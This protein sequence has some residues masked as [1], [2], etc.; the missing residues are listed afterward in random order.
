M[1]RSLASPSFMTG[2]QDDL[3]APDIYTISNAETIN[4]VA[5]FAVMDEVKVQQVSVLQGGKAMLEKAREGLK[6][7]QSVQG[8]NAKGTGAFD[9]LMNS[10][11]SLSNVMR[12]LPTGA[13]G[14][15]KELGVLVNAAS[16][17]VQKGQG[18]VAQINGVKQTFNQLK[19]GNVFAK[20]DSIGS[21]INTLSGDSGVFSISNIKEQASTIAGVVNLASANGIK[22]AFGAILKDSTDSALLNKV[23][24]ACLST[25]AITSD[26]ASLSSMADKLKPGVIMGF[27]PNILG[28]FSKQYIRPIEETVGSATRETFGAIKDTFGKINPNWLTASRNGEEIT[29]LTCVMGSS[30]DFQKTMATAIM[31]DPQ[32]TDKDHAMLAVL[33]E[34]PTDVHREI[35]QQFPML[36]SLQV[37]PTT[38]TTSPNASTST[39]QQ[40]PDAYLKVSLPQASTLTDPPARNPAWSAADQA[41]VAAINKRYG[42]DVVKVAK[43]AKSFSMKEWLAERITEEEKSLMDRAP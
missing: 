3:A 13:S 32:A 20:I 1:A 19:S 11:G 27:N 23:A 36:T 30:K 2:P 35:V 24:S 34:K 10:A 22:G 12:N 17:I 39:S 37:T 26:L 31:T 4:K 16:G 43:Y 28:D 25:T 41:A 29:D 7:A 6:L 40:T 15:S 8:L 9:K 14:L 5:P 18:A 33:G 38:V 21:M 42:Y